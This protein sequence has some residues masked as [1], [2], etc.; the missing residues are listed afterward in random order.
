MSEVNN[1][2][3]KQSFSPYQGTRLS[4]IYLC[5]ASLFDQSARERAL[6]NDSTHPI[7][8]F[9]PIID[10]L[11]AQDEFYQK[12]R[13]ET[14]DKYRNQTKQSRLQKFS[15]PGKANESNDQSVRAR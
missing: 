5:H 15:T 13:K 7:G 9:L 3:F 11:I 8:V 4:R 14:L 12:K 10:E 2:L 6:V 1:M